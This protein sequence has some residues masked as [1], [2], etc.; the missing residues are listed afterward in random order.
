P[1]QPIEETL[2][3]ADSAGTLIWA[4]HIA[5]KSGI[6]F[7]VTNRDRAVP[8][9]EWHNYHHLLAFLNRRYDVVLANLPENSGDANLEILSAAARIYIAAT[10]EFLS[11][12][13]ARQRIRELADAQIDPSRVRIVI[14]RWHG[15]DL[16]PKEISGLLGCPVEGAFP[17]DYP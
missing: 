14:N 12:T 15:H 17:N 6:D 7:L 11:L 16:K 9:A 4:R 13:L 10:P 3:L 5:Q 1:Q 8:P 2:Q